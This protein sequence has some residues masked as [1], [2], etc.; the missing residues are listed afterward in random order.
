MSRSKLWIRRKLKTEIH[1]NCNI[2]RHETCTFVCQHHVGH[3][4]FVRGIFYMQ[5]VS[6]V[7]SIIVFRSLFVIIL[8]ILLVIK[9]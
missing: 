3:V 2:T 7:G 9:V 8:E 4:P 1:R 6:V 5:D